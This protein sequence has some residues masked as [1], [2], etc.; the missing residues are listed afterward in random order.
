MFIRYVWLRVASSGIYVE[1]TRK[2][3]LKFFGEIYRRAN[4]ASQVTTVAV[5]PSSECLAPL[6]TS[7]FK[8]L[9]RF[10]LSVGRPKDSGFN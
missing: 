6:N 8:R 5:S 1:T 3:P 9:E 10:C 7:R 2:L 4:K